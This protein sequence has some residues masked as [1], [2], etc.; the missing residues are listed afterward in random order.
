MKRLPRIL[1]ITEIKFPNITCAFNTS[2]YR[3]I[4]MVKLFDKLGI[5]KG[6]FGYEIIKNKQLFNAASLDNNTLAW[7]TLKEIIKISE[8]DQL[9]TF[10]HLDPAVLYNN[11]VIDKK[12]T[13]RFNLGK[14]IKSIRKRYK[15]T[16]ETLAESIGSN[17]QYIS[18]IENN[19]A[20]LEFKTLKKIFE[21][22]LNQ[23]VFISHYEKD[24]ILKSHSNSI[25]S[26]EFIDWAV[27]KKNELTL[28]EGIDKKVK[29]YLEEVNIRT[30]KELSMIEFPM[31]FNMLSARRS[32]DFFHHP[33]LWLI[34]ARFITSDD[35]LNVIHLQRTISSKT[36]RGNV[37]SKIE[38]MAK[39]EINDEIFEVD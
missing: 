28:I 8:N 16:Q 25:L 5:Q 34:Q 19:K 38:E 9:E 36:T 10:F 30:T 7:K 20:D 14:K 1:K 24:D 29:K 11:S 4:N 26:F 3:R 37:F 6:D 32:I 31:L 35:W 17:K 39:V 27:K 12:F 18:K 33:E 15:L 21:L 13:S 2:E 23:N 22:G